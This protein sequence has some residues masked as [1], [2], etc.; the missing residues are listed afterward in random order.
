MRAAG[1][2][3]W[4]V[5]LAGVLFALAAVGHGARRLYR[6][7]DYEL[8]EREPALP[9]RVVLGVLAISFVVVHAAWLVD[10]L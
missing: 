8:G 9:V 10:G 1:P 7:E 4:V 3:G 5:L 6:G 2:L